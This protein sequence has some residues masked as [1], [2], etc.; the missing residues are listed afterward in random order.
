M[1]VVIHAVAAKK[2]GGST[3]RLA[4]TAEALAAVAPDNEYV[5]CLDSSLEIELP[6]GV[7]RVD[8]PIRSGP[9]RFWWDQVR[10]RRLL[11]EEEPDVSVA[12]LQ[13]AAL[14]PKLPQVV[15]LSDATYFCR[16]ASAFRTP[17][18][19]AATALRARLI[20]RSVSTA[21]AVVVPSTTMASGVADQLRPEAPVEVLPYAWEGSMTGPSPRATAGRPLRLVYVSHLE[22]HKAHLH[23][24]EMGA[25]LAAEGVD[26]ELT[27]TAG[28]SDDPGLAAQLDQAIEAAGLTARFS[29]LDRIPAAEVAG[30]LGG[31]D[32]FVFPS[33]CESFGF[34]MVEALAAGLPVVAADTPINRE[35]LGPGALYYPP[36]RPKEAAG[37]IAKLAGD[38]G[39]RGEI[40]AQ[41]Q[42]HVAALLPDWQQ[43]ARRLLGIFE[44]AANTA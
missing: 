7:R 22:P 14:W 40:A 26:F 24:V 11:A 2:S 20:A 41:G 15:L 12:F 21:S 36:L 5:F 34:P 37:A 43:Y 10:Y 23:L 17:R 3:H 32:V 6:Q 1:K 38:A 39:L 18:Q 42:A 9:G 30:L 25:A 27:A 4:R 8:A 28:R 29:V 19:K 44:R 16:Y 31:A 13:L 33:L 35:V